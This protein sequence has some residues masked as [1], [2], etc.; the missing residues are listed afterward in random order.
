[1][2][3]IFF[4]IDI[5]FEYV[6]DI[7]KVECDLIFAG[8]VK[9]AWPMGMCRRRDQ[10]SRGRVC[11]HLQL[12]HLRRQG[13]AGNGQKGEM[14]RRYF[15]NESEA[16]KGWRQCGRVSVYWPGKKARM[17]VVLWWVMEEPVV[18]VTE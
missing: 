16:E 7:L 5:P 12:A 9:R 13:D 8:S 4:S 17:G 1:M 18:R 10:L 6:N 2:C 3:D 14:G 15:A 11:H